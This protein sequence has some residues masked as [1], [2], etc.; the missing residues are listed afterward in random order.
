MLLPDTENAPA[1][2]A[3][4][5]A[6]FAPTG[7]LD[8]MQQRLIDDMA[9]IMYGLDYG[10]TADLTD[11]V[12]ETLPYETRLEALHLMVVV[13]LMEHPLRPEVAQSVLEFAEKLNLPIQLLEDARHLAD[14]QIAFAYL[15]FQRHGWY[16]HETLRES[17]HGK[18]LELLRS[19]IAYIG[20]IPDKEI[21]Q[22]WE[23]L[24]VCPDGSWGRAVAQF[25]L[26]HKFPFPGE[27]HGIFEV[28]ARHD[29]MHVLCG[30]GTEPAGELNVFAFIAASMN[31]SRGLVLLA[32]T[33]GLFQNGTIKHV[34]MKRIENASTD[35]LS[36]PGVLE[37]WA[38]SFRRG[39]QCRVDVMGTVDLFAYKD[40][41]LDEA[42]D[43]FGVVP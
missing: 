41:A 33:L 15:D 5:K 3:V 4:V 38:D 17:T 23:A 14:D 22:R 11:E 19:K 27:K 21:A 2:L 24:L 8:D 12:L 9:Q 36:I 10:A 35:T 26:D 18:W 43:F 13:E 40:M 6:A 29:W 1:A 16:A 30:Y 32:V 20:I 34:G 42:R 25:Y 39:A 28:G 7:G 31:D 37:Q